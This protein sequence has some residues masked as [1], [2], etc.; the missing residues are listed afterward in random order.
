MKTII[1]GR[2]IA[3]EELNNY[4]VG[5]LRLQEMKVAADN[6]DSDDI[7]YIG[8]CSIT[9]RKVTIGKAGNKWCVGRLAPANF[10]A[11]FMVVGKR[12]VVLHQM[13]SGSTDE[14]MRDYECRDFSKLLSEMSALEI[15]KAGGQRR[16]CRRRAPKVNF[17]TAYTNTKR[18][19]ANN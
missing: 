19:Y 14:I 17:S 8:R 10:R 1:K 2:G 5:I 18:L 12:I 16:P 13:F 3:I 9:R 15:F 7:E 6:F 4:S 11:H